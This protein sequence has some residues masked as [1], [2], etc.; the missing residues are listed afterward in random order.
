MV[1]PARRCPVSWSP[2]TVL[3]GLAVTH[4]PPPRSHLDRVA[5]ACRRRH[6]RDN[7]GASECLAGLDGQPVARRVRRARPCG[8]R[9]V[10]RRL[11]GLRSPS[12]LDRQD[13]D[14]P[15]CRPPSRPQPPCPVVRV[16]AARVALAVLRWYQELRNLAWS[17]AR[18]SFIAVK[19]WRCPV[20]LQVVLLA[21]CIAAGRGGVVAMLPQTVL[22]SVATLAAAAAAKP[23]RRA[24][25]LHISLARRS[26]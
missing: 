5:A 25:G 16:G 2:S 23:A 10:G 9:P 12:P 4:Y 22:P 17:A 19:C 24:P 3:R 15:P 21:R 1:Y 20:V 14:L 18:D 11:L 13:R 7:S 26:R 6:N 8:P